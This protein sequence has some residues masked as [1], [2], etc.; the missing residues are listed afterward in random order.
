MNY[1]IVKGGNQCVHRIVY[2]TF[3]GDIPEG[4][5]ID[6]VNSV[7]DDNRLINL[8]LL[9]HV[10]NIRKSKRCKYPEFCRLFQE[11]Y[12]TAS[13]KAYKLY[14]RELAYY[15]SHNNTCRWQM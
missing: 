3:V 15:K 10:E 6:H 1:A 9:T 2:E 4:Y 14:M 7:R 11:H 8:Q 12:H 5:E 13:S